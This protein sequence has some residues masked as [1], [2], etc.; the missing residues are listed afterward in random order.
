MWAACC[1][2][3]AVVGGCA[4]AVAAAA[5]QQAA[6]P[7]PSPAQKTCADSLRPQH[8]SPRGPARPST[9][10]V[11]RSRN[12]SGGDL[13][14]ACGGVVGRAC[15]ARSGGSLPPLTPLQPGAVSPSLSALQSSPAAQRPGVSPL[16]P[17]T[18]LVGWT[19][20]CCVE[21][22]AVQP[23]PSPLTSP[24]PAP[25]FLPALALAA[26]PHSTLV[27][28]CRPR[29]PVVGCRAACMCVWAP[30]APSLPA[31]TPAPQSPSQL[32]PPS[33][34]LLW[35]SLLLAGSLPSGS[36]LWCW[37]A[38]ARQRPSAS[39]AHLPRPS[40]CHRARASPW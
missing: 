27:R 36:A 10:A 11:S 34:A 40:Q 21:C 2:R 32:L 35:Y 18:F 29:P 3:A 15:A 17:C 7:A 23:G 30:L 6:A 9:A 20:V 1:G 28:W 25:Q 38:P 14:P 33:L 37:S 39:P 4:A 19:A 12:S 26:L 16:P 24:P 13:R 8:E 31:G 5:R 22:V